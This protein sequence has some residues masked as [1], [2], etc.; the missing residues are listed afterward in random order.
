MTEKA[1]GPNTDVSR[2]FIYYN[3]RVRDQR[4]TQVIDSGCIM[5]SAIEALE[6]FGTRLESIWPYQITQINSRLNNKAYREELSVTR[7]LKHFE[8]ML[9]YM[10]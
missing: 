1:T 8:L 9:I 7:L 2:L 10:K 4:S 5:T 6:E 3:A